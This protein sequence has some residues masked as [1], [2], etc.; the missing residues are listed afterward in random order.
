MPAT[1]TNRCGAMRCM[2]AEEPRE[3]QSILGMTAMP[4]NDASGAAMVALVTRS[5]GC[6]EALDADLRDE[7]AERSV[8]AI[9]VMPTVPDD[10]K[11]QRGHLE[12]CSHGLDRR[13]VL[14]HAGKGAGHRQDEIAFRENS[15]G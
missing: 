7:I 15:G 5:E 13:E 14:E 2:L 3:H 8:C 1:G 6:A 10:R 4:P 12:R 9:L 11:P